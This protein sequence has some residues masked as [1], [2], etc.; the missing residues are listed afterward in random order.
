MTR[1][2]LP[3][4]G[5]RW[6]RLLAVDTREAYAALAVD[7]ALRRRRLAVPARG[8]VT[9]TVYGTLRRRGTIDWMLGQCSDRPLESLHPAVRNALRLAVYEMCFMRTVPGPVAC[10]E[11]VALTKRRGPGQAAGFVNAVCRRRAAPPPGR[12]MAVAFRRLK[13][14]SQPSRCRL[15]TRSGW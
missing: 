6:T 14:P 1:S 13:T 8:Y 11:A 7:A 9:E 12:R 10:H 2:S 4:R 5:R 3:P 15:R